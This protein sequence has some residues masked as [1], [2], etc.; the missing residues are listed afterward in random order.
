MCDVPHP[1][2]AEDAIQ[3]AGCAEQPHMTSMQGNEGASADVCLL[4]EQ[5]W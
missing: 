1:A 3:H 4:G 2:I 5:N